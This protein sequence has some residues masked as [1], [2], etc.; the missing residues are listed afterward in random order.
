MRK[1]FSY[2]LFSLYLL[3]KLLKKQPFITDSLCVN[4]GIDVK[5]PSLMCIFSDLPED[6]FVFRKWVFAPLFP[7]LVFLPPKKGNK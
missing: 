4:A 6:A 2:K 7:S 5:T 3:L 1:T